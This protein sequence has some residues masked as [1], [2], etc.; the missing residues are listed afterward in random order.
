MIKLENVSTY[1]LI[2]YAKRMSKKNKLMNDV[3]ELLVLYD[4]RDYQKL[5]DILDSDESEFEYVSSFLRDELDEVIQEVKMANS[6][7]LES[8][9][10]V[11]DGYR[12]SLVDDKTLRITDE[13]NKGNV[14][15]YSCPMQ[16]GGA[17]INQLKYMTIDEIKHY[18]SHLSSYKLHNAF[19]VKR[20]FGSE[21]VKQVVDRVRFYEQQVLRQAS[22]TQERDINLFMLNKKEKDEIVELQI[23]DIVSY[24][25]DTAEVCVWGNLSDTQKL[26]MMRAVLAVRGEYALQDR[27]MLINAISNYTTLS[28]L[29][30]GVIKKKTLDRFILR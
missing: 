19:A 30:Q 15:L 13:S 10:F 12:D 24:F 2:D 27:R 20:N 14:L 11:F 7:G 9:I 8:E 1:R 5:K 18:A 26:R 23:K 22:E 4:I 28:E 17:R 25:L 3:Y 21:T 29:E 6:L 16:R